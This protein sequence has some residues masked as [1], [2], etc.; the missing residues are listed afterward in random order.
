MHRETKPFHFKI[1]SLTSNSLHYSLS[2]NQW[3]STSLSFNQSV[4]QP[5][6]K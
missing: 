1:I 4:S 5:L 3:Q 6:S 2:A